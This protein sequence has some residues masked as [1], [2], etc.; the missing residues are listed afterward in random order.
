LLGLA[1]PT[2][3]YKS[4][5]LVSDGDGILIRINPNESEVPKGH[6]GL[7]MTGLAALKEINSLYESF[8]N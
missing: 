8:S 3:R 4:Q 1:V 2:I 5:S 7:P 6:V